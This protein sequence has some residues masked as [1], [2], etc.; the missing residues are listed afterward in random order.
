VHRTTPEGAV[1]VS[2][3]GDES[4]AGGIAMK[5]TRLLLGV[6]TPLALALPALAA[7]PHDGAKPAAEIVDA[8][9]AAATPATPAAVADQPRTSTR[10][11]AT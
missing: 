5:I 2:R 8:P 7:E 9:G 11:R 4:A 1:R 6:I 10:S 3:G